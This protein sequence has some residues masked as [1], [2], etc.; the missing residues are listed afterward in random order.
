MDAVICITTSRRVRRVIVVSCSRVKSWKK[1]K[2]IILH[3]K[4]CRKERKT[5]LEKK[6]K[7][8][9]GKRINLQQNAK[10]TSITW[11]KSDT[12]IIGDD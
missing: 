12:M 1:K 7:S 8:Q 4:E 9:V 6:K 10:T 2:K 3:I 11:R 5:H